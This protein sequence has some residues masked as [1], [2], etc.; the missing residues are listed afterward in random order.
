MHSSI[1]SNMNYLSGLQGNEKQ[2]IANWSHL[3]GTSF[4]LQT[5]LYSKSYDVFQSIGPLGRCFL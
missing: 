1:N 5:Y 2:S 3:G 4:T